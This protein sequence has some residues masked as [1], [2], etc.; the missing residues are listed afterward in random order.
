MWVWDSRAV[1]QTVGGLG[2]LSMEHAGSLLVIPVSPCR[3]PC[4]V[5]W[6][7]LPVP[8]L[9]LA[10]NQS[11]FAAWSFPLPAAARE[12]ELRQIRKATLLGTVNNLVFGGGPII[13][14]LAGKYG[15]APQARL[16]RPAGRAASARAGASKRC[17]R[18]APA[19]SAAHSSLLTTAC[20]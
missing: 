20:C 18:A 11:M 1:V 17:L 16:G 19:I 13:I 3:S 9:L 15:A 10:A 5:H 6:R 4:C 12:A 8:P 14:S 2:D 7:A